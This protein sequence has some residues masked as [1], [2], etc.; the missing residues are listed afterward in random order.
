MSAPEW[1]PEPEPRE[2]DPDPD[3]QLDRGEPYAWDFTP[4][5]LTTDREEIP[6]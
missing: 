6:W 1:W 5:E 2:S 3:R 4:R